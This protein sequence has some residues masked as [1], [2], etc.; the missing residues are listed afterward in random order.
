MGEDFRQTRGVAGV[1]STVDTYVLAAGTRDAGADTLS[2]LTVG[3]CATLRRMAGLPSCRDG[4]TFLAHAPG[5]TVEDIIKPGRRINLNSGSAYDGSAEAP[6]QVPASARTVTAGRDPMGTVHD[7]ILATPGAV[8]THRLVGAQT[9]ATILLDHRVPDALEYVRNT[10]ARLDP[11]MNV[12]TTQNLERDKQ[13]TSVQTGLLIGGTITMALIAAS[14]LV[15][16]IEQLRERKRL[17]SVLVAFGTRRGTLAW[18]VLW[19]TA[20]PVAVGT[21][22]AVAGGLALGY[23]ML[24]MVAKP[25]RDWWVFLP[26]AGA[27]AALI[28]LVTALSLPPLW[29]MMRPEGL[30]TE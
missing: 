12:R 29:R 14:M 8:D 9:G 28:L 18:S 6:W 16:Q 20:V 13:Y 4:D 19:Q 27:G 23:A 25:V 22:L 15:S 3:D 10:A 11:A 7:G 30:R 5:K 1:L 17:L 2:T 26:Y 24:R 21:A